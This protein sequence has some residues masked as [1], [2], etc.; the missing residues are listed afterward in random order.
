MSDIIDE[1]KEF[2]ATYIRPF[3][4]KF[5]AEEHLPVSMI[6]QLADRGYLGATIPVEYHGMGMDPVTYGLL[7]E[8]I[9]KACAST[10][11]L[12]TVH[13]SIVAEAIMKFGTAKQKSFWLPAMASG[14]KIGAFALTEP[15]VGSDAKSVLT[16]YELK[17]NC[18]VLNGK[19]KWISFAAIADFFIVIASREGQVTAFLVDVNT[20]GIIRKPMKGLLGNRAAHIA[21]L[22]LQDVIVPIENRLG[23]EGDGFTYIVNTALDHGR[24]SIAWAGLALA[25]EAL[26]AMNSYALKRR[27]FGKKLFMHQSIQTMI[28]EATIG[29][30]AARALCMQVAV[31]RKEKHIESVVETIIAKCYTSQLAMQITINAVQLH[32]GN[33]CSPEYPV[34]RLFR[35][36]KILEIIEGTIQIHQEAITH[37]SLQQYGK[38]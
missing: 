15:D 38:P 23:N 17:D 25:Q 4:G 1:V 6:K 24:Y 8:Q 16:T 5:D 31:K 33:G 21:A 13:T 10:R 28:A 29:V 9:G 3:A 19:K 20:P 30:N 27:Q 18:Y 32:G 22:D 7:T 35:E 11:S 36:A 26:E 34:E 12:L 2:A 37:Y 14:K